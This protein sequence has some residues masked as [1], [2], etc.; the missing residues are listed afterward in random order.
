M[1]A[2]TDRVDATREA[3]VAAAER[4][5]AEQ[6][7][8]AVSARQISDAAGQGNNTAV[9]YHFGTKADLVRALL[10]RHAEPIADMRA[11]LLAGLGT[12]PD[13]Y[14]WVDCMVRPQ[15]DHLESLGQPTWYARFFAQAL[16]DPAYRPIVIDERASDVPLKRVGEGF[17]LCL[18]SLPP[19]VQRERRDMT[20]QLLIHTFAQHER[21]VSEGRSTPRSAW[22]E[23]ADGLVDAIVGLC[24]APVRTRQSNSS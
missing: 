4:L 16:T 7:L 12:S 8:A 18:D 22:S 15:A 10:R 17:A 9:G 20:V 14:D 6:G 19:P 24:T 3:L 11:R 5:F 23:V 13:L 2:R 21:R 1:S